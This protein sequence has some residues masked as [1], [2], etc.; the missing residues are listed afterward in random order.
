M[1][2]SVACAYCGA[3]DRSITRDHVFSRALFPATP[4]AKGVNRITVPVCFECNNAYSR[5]EAHFRNVVASAGSANG[6][7]HMV[8]STKVTRSFYEKDGRKRVLELVDLTERQTIDGVDRLTIFPARD[9]RVL[10]IARKCIRGLAHHH[11]LSTAV[12]EDR[13]WVDVLKYVLPDGWEEELAMRGAERD[14]AEYG[15]RTDL[16]EGIESAWLLRFYERVTFIGTVDSP[17][18]RR[19]VGPN[20]KS[21]ALTAC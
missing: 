2:R 19:A 13:V 5:D 12:P 9:E 14:I 11:G 18:H 20:G 16:G 3:T 4:A 7:N 17:G 15:F 10:R 8:W 1:G 21:A 6:P